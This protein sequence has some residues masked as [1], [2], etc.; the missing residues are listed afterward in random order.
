[1]K[2]IHHKKNHYAPLD[3]GIIGDDKFTLA[4]HPKSMPTYTSKEHVNLFI[5]GEISHLCKNK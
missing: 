2:K 1:M 5:G 4:K 3:F